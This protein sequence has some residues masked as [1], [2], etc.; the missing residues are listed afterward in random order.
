LMEELSYAMSHGDIGR[1]EEVLIQWIFIFKGVGKHKYALHMQRFLT[2]LHLRYPEGLRRAIRYNMLVNPKGKADTFR[3]VDW[4][5]ELMNLYTK[6]PLVMIYRDAHNV[7][8]RNY[9][10]RKLTTSHSGPD[11]VASFKAALAALAKNRVHEIDPGRK[12]KYK[13]PDA[14]DLG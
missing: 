7:V 13:I 5:V 4:V 14:I 6:S 1:M 11:M 9:L 10:V 8:E 12:T 3:A 2:D